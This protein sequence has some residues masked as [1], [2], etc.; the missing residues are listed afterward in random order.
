MPPHPRGYFITGTDTGVGKTY[1]A[2]ALCHALVQYGLKVG[3]MKPV[4]SGCIRTPEGLRSEDALA[5]QAASNV[6]LAYEDINPYAFE[7]AIAP[8]IAAR[9]AGQTIEF[10]HLHSAFKRVAKQSDVVIVE[11]AGG[12]LTPI[13]SHHTLDELPR[14]W[15]LAVILVVGLRLGCLNHA[16][17][18]ARAIE[19]NG[20]ELAGWVA[21]SIDPT[22]ERPDENVGYLRASLLPP[23]LGWLPNTIA[24]LGLPCE[25][26]TIDLAPLS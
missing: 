22:F 8:H 24:G 18:T 13:D 26:P 20:S 9:E 14:R 2:V 11:S 10:N 19:A 23:C 21:N 4:A 12:W 6:P 1:V 7:P 16:L 17:L 15:Q 5:L 3:V 25:S